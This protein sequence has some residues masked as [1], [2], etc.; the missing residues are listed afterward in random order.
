MHRLH[1]L[2]PNPTRI[3]EVGCG[4]GTGLSDLLAGYPSAHVLGIDLSPQMVAQS[5]ARNAHAIRS[6]RLELREADVRDVVEPA[7]LMLAVHVLY[8]WHDPATVLHHLRTR[9][10]GDGV[11][12]LGYRCRRDMPPPARRDFPKE[13]HRLY[14]S[15]KDVS[16]LLTAAGFH[17][18]QNHVITRNG[19]MLGWLTTGQAR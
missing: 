12:A 17:D 19:N 16:A 9:L 6:G 18:V 3:V 10:T 13:G 14:D 15:E 1:Q 2:Y 7:D 5:Q 11:L 8:F 4:P